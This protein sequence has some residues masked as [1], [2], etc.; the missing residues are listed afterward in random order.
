MEAILAAAR[1]RRQ[2][3]RQEG[4]DG[5]EPGARADSSAALTD[6]LR[7]VESALGPRTS[8]VKVQIEK[9]RAWSREQTRP[10]DWH[11][12][13]TTLDELEDQLEALLR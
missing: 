6:L 5:P 4:S 2:V 12:L 13:W 11:A 9:L 10:R 7:E 3:P 1:Q 8:A